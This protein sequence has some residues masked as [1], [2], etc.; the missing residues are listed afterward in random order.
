MWVSGGSKAPLLS[1]PVVWCRA[2]MMPAGCGQIEWLTVALFGTIGSLSCVC[3]VLCCRN[4]L[5]C[6]RQRYHSAFGDRP[7]VVLLGQLHGFLVCGLVAPAELEGGC[8][9]HGS[10]ASAVM[11]HPRVHDQWHE[12]HGLACSFVQEAKS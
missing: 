7:H 11:V 5:Y 12:D 2:L 9:E 3:N 10:L 4:V 1:D 6:R 8:G